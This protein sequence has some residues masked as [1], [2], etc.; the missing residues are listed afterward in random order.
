MKTILSYSLLFFAV[1][2][3]IGCKKTVE[4][5][6]SIQLAKDRKEHISSISYN[7]HFSIP[8]SKSNKIIGKIDIGFNIDKKDDVVFD[9][10]EDS[11]KVKAVTIDERLVDCIIE[12]GHIVISSKNIKSGNNSITVD[13]IAGESSLNRKNEFL[14]TLLV[15]DR[16]STAFPCFDQPDLK[17]VYNLSLDI[18]KD[19]K[20]VTNGKLIKE[21]TQDTIKTL[22]FG[23]TEP[24]STY[25]FAFVVG[26]F[27]TIS[28]VE[29]GRKIVMYHRENDSLKVK[30]NLDAIFKS[31][32]H[33]LAWL[34][35]YTGIDYPFGK[36][37]IIIIPDFQYGGMEH[38]GAIYYRDSQLFLDEKPSVN[39]KLRAANL[40][41]HEVSH[42]WF[43]DLVTMRWFNDVWLK[44]VFAGFIADKIVNPQF[45]D[46][47]HNLRFMLSHY[48]RAYSVDRTD[49][50]NP[51]RQNLD[52]LLFAGTLYGDIIYH[53]API[54]MMQLEMLMGEELFK[55]GVK[56]YLESYSMG[57][58]DW[59]ELIAILDPL[60]PEDLTSWSKA[61][62]NLPGMPSIH[63]NIKVQ[64]EIVSEFKLIQ[65]KSVASP[66]MGMNFRIKPF[67]HKVDTTFECLMVK[68]TLEV[69]NIENSEYKGLILPNSD[70]RG[71]GAFYPDS[72]SLLKLLSNT[73][74]INDDIARAS[75]YVMLNEL[76]LNGKV[77]A[78]K[79]FTLLVDYLQ[80]ETEP[81]V[82]Q[83]ILNGLEM[84]LWN[85][86]SDEQ[87]YAEGKHIENV[88]FQL[89]SSSTIKD[90]EKKP[91]FQTYTRIATTPDA[92]NYIFKIWN[93]KIK[94]KGINI[95][96]SDYMTLAYELAVRGFKNSDSI[97]TAQEQKIKNTDRKAKFKFVRRAVS[98]DLSVRDSFFTTL[99]NV[100][101]RRPEAWVT[102]ALHYLNHPLRAKISIK[103]L[104][105][106]LDLLPEIQKT[107]DIFFPKSWLESM[108]WGYSS[109]EAYAIVNNWLTENQKLPKTLKDKV[110]QSSDLLKQ[111]V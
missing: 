104:K 18:P 91:L 63:A 101:N 57:N 46:V 59:E 54:M 36:L 72:I 21:T 25:L 80:K 12:K 30:R 73:T 111:K 43:G 28:R 55:K 58:A 74:A 3:F 24:I 60:T 90:D 53:K 76:F 67:G 40:I 84:V 81:Q 86:F 68:D 77:D 35:E 70:G 100:A 92:L 37:D 103:Y 1:I 56:K 109:N 66:T 45:T 47:N 14:Y 41:A 20:A 62:V 97:L 82:R 61:W 106:S 64:N 49:G 107:G 11:L 48:P 93:D 39:Q 79:Y 98:V 8:K 105:P 89:I 75:W 23:S 22:S 9:F 50:A 65:S 102:E 87:R 85:F 33:S 94:I 16:A 42:Q 17:A 2:S 4:K 110:L 44:E 32:F 69:K 51:I 13:F 6:V 99:S 34:K 7:L 5:G 83:Y 95:D 31:H 10:R 71:Y 27:D 19:W 15:P 88:I 26:R 78:G 29:N 38:P 96:E 52:N 108:L